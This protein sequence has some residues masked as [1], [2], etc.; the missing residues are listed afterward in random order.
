MAFETLLCET[1][2]DGIALLTLNRP[3]KRNALS[4]Q[5]RGEIVECLNRFAGDDAV[6]VVVL[7]GLGRASVPALT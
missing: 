1:R 3:E 6:R 5:L 2:D 4:R 7:W